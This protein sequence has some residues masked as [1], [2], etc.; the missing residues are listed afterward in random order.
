MHEI[1]GSFFLEGKDDIAQGYAELGQKRQI[2]LELENCGFLAATLKISSVFIS[3][4]DEVHFRGLVE[5]PDKTIWSVSGSLNG[6]TLEATFEFWQ[7]LKRQEGWAET[8]EECGQL[9]I[10]PAH[11][12]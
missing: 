4:D 5:L 9:S 10:F 2:W 3:N 8:P 7:R 1:R 11:L 6:G 12:G